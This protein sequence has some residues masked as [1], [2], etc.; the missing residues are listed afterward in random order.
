MWILKLKSVGSLSLSP[1]VLAQTIQHDFRQFKFASRGICASED[2]FMHA[3]SLYAIDYRPIE[4]SIETILAP[5][6]R[7]MWSAR[8]LERSGESNVCVD[9]IFRVRGRK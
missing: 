8:V 4:A 9:R 2:H 5:F 1:F 6:V 7:A 3:C